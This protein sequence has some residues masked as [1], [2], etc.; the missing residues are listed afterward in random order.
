M[1]VRHRL[2]AQGLSMGDE[3]HAYAPLGVR[4]SLPVPFTWASGN[5]TYDSLRIYLK[6]VRVVA[7]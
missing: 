7:K 4:H 2:R 5:R 6:L 1:A 3:H